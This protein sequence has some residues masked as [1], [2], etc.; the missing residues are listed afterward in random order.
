MFVCMSMCAHTTG[1]NS[2]GVHIANDPKILSLGEWN[3]DG[4]SLHGAVIA[5][6]GG[7]GSYMVSSL[8]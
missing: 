5:Y 1:G 8:I 6:I 7:G 2:S 4:T 3:M